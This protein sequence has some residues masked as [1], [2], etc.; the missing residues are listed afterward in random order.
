MK[1]I[2]WSGYEWILQERWGL[3]HPEKPYTWYD[4]TAVEIADNG[5]LLLKTHKNP[6]YF[7]ELNVTANIGMGIVSCVD[8]FKYG[9]YEIN[10]KL[11]KGK[12]LWPAFWMWSWDTWPPEID[13]LEG[14][15]NGL[16]SY[17]TFNLF[18]PWRVETS[19]HY[20]ENGKRASHPG[21]T[22]RWG[23]KNPTNNF[24]KYRLEWKKDSVKYFYDNKLVKTV[25]D[26]MILKQLDNT[27]MNLI[28]NNHPRPTMNTN[29][30]TN[31]TFIIK[32]FK[33]TPL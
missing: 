29:K 2:N 23:W 8:R 31:S 27:T 3:I 9:I 14:Y 24:I 15:S 4:E 5:N 21:T 11:P 6:K 30:P 22:H 25:T 7:P 1:I 28:I 18:K 17:F 33:Y 13:I 19:I 20:W 26:P 12:H 10:A 16:G 32:Y